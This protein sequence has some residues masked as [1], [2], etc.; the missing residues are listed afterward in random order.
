VTRQDDKVGRQSRENSVLCTM[1]WLHREDDVVATVEKEGRG[2]GIGC[3]SDLHGRVFRLVGR[4]VARYG[5]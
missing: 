4:Q 5:H 1:S 3:A 2:P